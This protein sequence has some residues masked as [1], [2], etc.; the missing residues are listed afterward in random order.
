MSALSPHKINRH[1][2][3]WCISVQHK[4]HIW[5]RW[6]MSCGMHI[7]FNMGVKRSVRTSVMQQTFVDILQN[8]FYC[9]QLIYP[10]SWFFFCIFQN[11][12]CIFWVKSSK[13][14]WKHFDKLYN[15]PIYNYQTTQKKT[16]C[17][18]NILKSYLLTYLRCPPS[19]YID[20]DYPHLHTKYHY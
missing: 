12:L 15:V 20:I 8:C 3:R 10:V 18:T 5:H 2:Y 17:H 19:T 9:Q 6:H 4:C 7:Y 16:L 11:F 14:S 13:G 1:T